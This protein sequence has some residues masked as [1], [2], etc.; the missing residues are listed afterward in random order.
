[1]RKFYDS[2]Q[3]ILLTLLGVASVAISVWDFMGG[4]WIKS[5]DIPKLSLLMLGA[6]ALVIGFERL[7]LIQRLEKKLESFSAANDKLRS[8]PLQIQKLAE[9]GI[10]DFVAL[11]EIKKKLRNIN[12]PFCEIAD[13][14]LNDQARLLNSLAGGR[15]FVPE[16]Q[17]PRAHEWLAKSFK[18]RLDAVSHD[19]LRFW[20][21][22]ARGD[23]IK[24]SYFNLNRQAV[25]SGT[26]VTR[27]FIFTSRDLVEHSNEIVDVLKRQH[28][29]GIGWGVAVEEEVNQAGLKSLL[30][31]SPSIA[32][33]FALFDG[34]SAVSYFRKFHSR[35]FEAVFA[36]YD[37]HSNIEIVNI[38]KEIYKIL[39]TEC[40]LANSQFVDLYP[41]ALASKQAKDD[42]KKQ[43]S[44]YHDRLKAWI[45][46][47]SELS[48]CF[49]KNGSF[50]FDHDTFVLLASRE[51]EIQ[52]KVDLLG[53]IARK[54]QDR[55]RLSP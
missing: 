11:Y 10:Q 8:L 34:G 6:I 15:L 44:I 37:G 27:I 12:Q 55:L 22:G 52:E 23:S 3:Y 25:K 40:W 50:R 51:N 49:K 14:I 36:T 43:A 28:Q 33:D 45:S 39:V 4:P 2:F 46:Q 16:N 7:F 21:D 18:K 31:K 38:Q 29:V 41:D 35:N 30:D 42:V 20:I 24:A 5:T 48:D 32:K 1:V 26:I 54:S 13:E 19:D 47:D 17:I 53:K 9:Q